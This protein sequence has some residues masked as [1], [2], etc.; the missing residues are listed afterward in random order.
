M[1]YKNEGY[2][3]TSA[4]GCCSSGMPNS[5]QIASS[6]FL[7]WHL[8]CVDPEC[9]MCK[10]CSETPEYRLVNSIITL[11]DGNKGTRIICCHTHILIN[12]SILVCAIS[13]VEIGICLKAMMPHRIWLTASQLRPVKSKQHE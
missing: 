4:Y 1:S 2:F 12:N 13:P 6:F 7:S 5:E 11:K 3:T 10:A 9:K 8:S